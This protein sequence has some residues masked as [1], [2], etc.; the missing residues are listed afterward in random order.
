[1]RFLEDGETI[2]FARNLEPTNTVV[3]AITL[4]RHMREFWLPLGDLTIDVGGERRHVTALENLMTGEASGS[5][6]AGSNCIR[7]ET[8]MPALLLRCLA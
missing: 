1:M 2:A 3:A 6:G 8:A 5:N 7:S 4:S